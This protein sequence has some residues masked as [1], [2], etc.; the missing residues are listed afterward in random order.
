MDCMNAPEHPNI[1]GR[2][3]ICIHSAMVFCY[4]AL[5]RGSPLSSLVQMSLAKRWT[6]NSLWSHQVLWEG[7]IIGGHRPLIKNRVRRRWDVAVD[8]LDDDIFVNNI[9]CKNN[10]LG[11]VA[12][13]GAQPGL[14]T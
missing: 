3:D 6:R 2:E 9:L 8:E 4:R 14:Y 1:R 12:T 11:G 13:N 10:N 7:R 5:Q